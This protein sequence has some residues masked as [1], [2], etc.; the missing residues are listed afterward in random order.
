MTLTPD[1]LLERSQWDLFWVPDDVT[2]VVRDELAYIHCPRD[3]HYLNMV[4]RT[5]AVAER[6]P[7]LVDE[8]SRA[9]AGRRS[10]WLV[11]PTYDTAP[12]ERALANGGYA[13]DDAYRVSVI[14]CDAY[15][16]RPSPG[17]ICVTQVE[18]LDELELSF[19]ASSAAFGD[20]GPRTS[21]QPQRD[22]ALCS[23][24]H[25]RVVRVLATD[26]MSGEALGCGNMTIFTELRFGLLWGGGTAPDARGR[27]IYSA[28]LAQRIDAAA[29]RGLDRVGLLANVETSAPIVARQGFEQHGL[30]HYWERPA[31]LSR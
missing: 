25:P 27:G 1:E 18:T 16:R 3:R 8:V 10:R 14:A 22:L 20:P 6:L 31:L 11:P 13:R 29:R 26:E 17:G 24:P 21:D 2:K 19:R 30:A 4:T 28:L 12:L 5:R 9:H 15:R 23:G 7:G